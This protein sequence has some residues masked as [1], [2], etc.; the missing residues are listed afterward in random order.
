M[1]V[2]ID[3]HTHILPGMDD[4]SKSIEMSEQMLELSKAQGIGV[5]VGTPHF[6]ASQ[7][8]L[9][10][11]LKRR[12]TAY[13]NIYK[14]AAGLGIHLLFG[15]ETAFFTGIGSASGIEELAISGTSLFL[16]EM[17]F[18]EWT[19]SD[20]QEVEMLL[21]RGL[22]PVLAHIERFFPYQ[23]DKKIFDEL[24][25]LPVLSQ[26]N[27]EALV[28]WKTRRLV[29]KLFENNMAHLL[30]SDCHNISTRPPNLA[31]GR[32]IIEKKLGSPYLVQIDRLGSRLS[33]LS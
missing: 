11:F 13:G 26:V 20:I 27:A 7:M 1:S 17:P 4:G 23:K 24:Y 14:K 25:S 33:G 12:D 18:R 5:I 16:L 32:K 28:N 19:G 9:K 29:L 10:D 31:M 15:A 3:F 22:T 8:T 30:G 21:D 2:I 6:Y